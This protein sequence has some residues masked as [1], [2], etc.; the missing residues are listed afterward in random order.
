MSKKG[1]SKARSKRSSKVKKFFLI[2]L[3]LILVLLSAAF[4]AGAVYFNGKAL[5][6]D[7][8]LLKKIPQRTLVYDR[9]KKILGHVSGHGEN[10]LVV[11]IADVSKNFIQ[12]LLSREDARFYKHGGVDYRGVARAIVQN[13]KE[14]GIEQ[15]ASTLTMQLARNTFELRE[16][17][18][19]RKLQEVA[20]AKRLERRFSKDEILEFYVNRI[21]FGAGLYGVEKASQGFFMKPAS[22]LTLG[23][24]AMLAGIIRGPS[25]LNP[26]RDIKDAKATRDE[27]LARMLDDKQITQAEATAAKA[28]K[29]ILRPPGNRLATGSYVL[30][31]VHDLLTDYLYDEEIER[32]GLKIYTTID[33][34]LQKAAEQALNSHLTKIENRSGFLHPSR[35]KHKKGDA[36]A[37]TKYVQGAVVSLDNRSGGILAM[38]GGR[39]FAESPFNRAFQAKR[40]AGSTFKPFVYAVA[41]DR[42]GLLPG[43]YV[44]D[45][46]VRIKTG[47]GKIWSPRNSDGKF[48]GLQPAAVGLMN[49]RNTMSVRVGQIAGMGNVQSMAENIF[50]KIPDSPVSFLGAFETTPL[51]MTSAFSTFPSKGLNRAPYII[52]RI[53]NS[54]GDVLFRAKIHNK[55]IF[56]ESV[57]WLTSDVLEETIDNGT[58]KASRSSGYKAPGGGKTGT[59]NDYRDAWFV[60][61]TDK[62]TTG[63]WVGM[64]Q[65]K[66]IIN[67]GYGSTLA[68]PIWTE[69][70]KKAETVGYK[71]GPLPTPSKM[72]DV[73]LCRECGGISN[74]RTIYPY[75]MKL[76][77]DL[78]PRHKC[79]GHGRNIFT[80]K[81]RPP[82]A[83]PVPGEDQMPNQGEG[84]GGFFR[85]LKRLLFGK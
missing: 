30:Q 44:S 21:Y 68:L 15:G 58:G 7:L 40:Q 85:G 52:E 65:P 74:R 78:M 12:A 67:R 37:S 25:L 72:R 70:M 4:I 48:T 10:R 83:I 13:L 16:K 3:L 56:S 26:F 33:S 42:A 46:E 32:G 45:D 84:V 17:S 60:G 22:E 27:V 2:S 23:E 18:L 77:P 53:E 57:S 75:Q 51:I 35:S 38:V 73:V 82:R 81:D 19:K 61:F 55:K 71:A 31:T 59:T 69:V 5:T 47:G 43:S 34:N 49:S 14:G 36:K 39:D 28:Q 66:K 63:V 8:K 76:P 11:P 80:N 50:G 41:F 24:G 54:G 1:K 79:P 64:D 29:I 20:L 6:Y 62:I 9:D